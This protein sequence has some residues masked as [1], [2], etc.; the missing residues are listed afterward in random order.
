MAT[1]PMATV[2]WM[3]DLEDADGVLAY[4]GCV[5]GD[6]TGPSET[7]VSKRCRQLEADGYPAL[8]HRRSYGPADPQPANAYIDKER[9]A[10]LAAKRAPS[11]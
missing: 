6:D 7:D 8:R 1:A 9:A 3:I 2:T 5:V 11:T 10:E 4:R